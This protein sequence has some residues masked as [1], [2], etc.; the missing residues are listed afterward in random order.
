MTRDG[1]ATVL[2]VDDEVDMRLLVRLVLEAARNGIEVV[3]E[4][5][6]GLDAVSA[7]DALDPPE[8]PD[9]VILDNRMPGRSGIEVAR[10]MLRRE[11]AQRVILFSGFLDSQLEAEASE[12]GVAACVSKSDVERLPALVL[13][14]TVPRS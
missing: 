12:L 5:A 11:P 10:E 3:G 8:V 14:M 6:D 9:V 4:A 2:I 1:H 7:F 13:E